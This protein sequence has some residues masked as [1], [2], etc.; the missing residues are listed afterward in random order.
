[1]TTN[2]DYK[3]LLSETSPVLLKWSQELDNM[4]IPMGIT[5]SVAERLRISAAQFAGASRDA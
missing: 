2:D 4:L 3:K 1:M 5:H